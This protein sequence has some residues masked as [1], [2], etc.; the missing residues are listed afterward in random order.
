MFAGRH[1]VSITGSNWCLSEQLGNHT[2]F[3]NFNFR[4]IHRRVWDPGTYRQCCY[5]LHK[6]HLHHLWLRF[7][8]DGHAC[9]WCTSRKSPSETLSTRFSIIQAQFSLFLLDEQQMMCAV[10]LKEGWYT[11]KT[12]FVRYSST[13]LFFLFAWLL[14]IDFYLFLNIL[15]PSIISLNKNNILK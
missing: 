14:F 12:S 15:T 8:G 1:S 3:K 11:W 10:S 7:T 9:Q 6:F 13:F 4:T 5:L 2:T